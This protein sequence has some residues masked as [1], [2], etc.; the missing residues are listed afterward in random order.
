MTLQP[1]LA[2]NATIRVSISTP[3]FA[4]DTQNHFSEMVP[5]NILQHDHSRSL[6]FRGPGNLG[7]HEFTG[8]GR[9]SFT[10]TRQRRK[11]PNF[12]LDGGDL[13]LFVCN[14]TLCWHQGSLN[15]WN[16]SIEYQNCSRHIGQNDLANE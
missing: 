12:L 16:V 2:R 9:A 11:R 7:C 13:L 14:C 1:T 15:I 3:I 10:G 5:V 8:C 6:Q 4:I